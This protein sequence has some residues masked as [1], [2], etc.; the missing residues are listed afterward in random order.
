M[1]IKFL[2]E[3]VV[4]VTLS[5]DVAHARPATERKTYKTPHAAA[6]LLKEYP[7]LV[8]TNV[9]KSSI[10][11]NWFEGAG[12]GKWVF[13]VADKTR[14]TESK[15]KAPPSAKTTVVSQTKKKTFKS[16]KK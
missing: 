7:N 5:V 3:N 6:A 16:K 2:S 8:V 9:V 15:R 14:P 10:V 11:K 12:E 4:E 1:N 13:E